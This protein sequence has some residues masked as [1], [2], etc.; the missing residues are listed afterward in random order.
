VAKGCDAMVDPTAG[1]GKTTRMARAIWSGSLSFGLVSIPVGLFSATQDKTVHFNQFEVGTS[2]RIRYKKVNE[3]TGREVDNARIVRGIDLGSGEVVQLTDEELAAADPQRS[4]TIEITDFVDAGEIDPLFY[5]AGY[6]LG[7]QGEGAQR[8]YS[9]LHTA[10]AAEGKVAV[11][12]MVMRNKEYLVTIRPGPKDKVLVLQTMYFPDEVR[13]PKEE[14]PNLPSADQV[15]S[16]RELAIAGQLVQAMTAPWLPENYRDTYRERIEQL[17]EAKRTGREIAAAEVPAVQKVV[18]LMAALE[19]SVKAAG[20]QPSPK[21]ARARTS[22][23]TVRPPSRAK[24]PAKSAG[25][26]PK[27]ASKRTAG[28]K[29]S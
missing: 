5:R 7:P 20:A 23:A 18:D 3:R 16:Q 29:A 26:A 11:A 24:K 27:A 28:K 14:L 25:A 10:M 9:L 12:T 4:R 19:A 2:D 15:F 8:A 1:L 22:A 17:I 6:Y 21:R 13:S